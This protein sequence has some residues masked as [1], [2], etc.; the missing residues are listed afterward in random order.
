LTVPNGALL[1]FGKSL[2]GF[3]TVN[4]AFVN[5]GDVYGG[6]GGNTLEFMD[7]V[8]GVGDFHNS[9]T[10]S[11]GY[12]PG[13]SAV[14]V[15]FDDVTFSATN[16]LSIELGGLSPGG[17]FDKLAASG[18]ATLGGTLGISLINNFTPQV[19]DEF[20][21]MTYASRTGEFSQ[22]TGWLFDGNKA[23][24][25]VYGANDLTLFATYQ[26]DANL[27]QTVDL[28]DLTIMANNWE[29]SPRSWFEGDFNG[30]GSVNLSDLT[31]MAN[32]WRAGVGGA[33]P[34]PATLALL[35]LGGCVGVL[36]RRRG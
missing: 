2:D 35:V 30:D 17:E 26:G 7:M 22:T 33:V 12:S 31:I 11:G 4:G 15:D 27:T 19:G 28:S 34:E 14:E 20:E 3:G 13:F 21:I 5:H 25:K 8:T 10:F 16:T 18:S 6:T 23:L 32:N 24:V 1:E 36:R 9:V 29:Q